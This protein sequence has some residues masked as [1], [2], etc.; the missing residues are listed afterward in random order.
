LDAAS[1]PREIARAILS[2]PGISTA[3][4]DGKRRLF[5]S[6][7]SLLIASAGIHR[8]TA[9]SASDRFGGQEK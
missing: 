1:H 8:E 2:L 7:L 5:E 4:I 9:L 3:G 6:A